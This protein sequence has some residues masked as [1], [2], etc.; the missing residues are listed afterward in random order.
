MIYLR[1]SANLSVGVGIGAYGAL[2]LDDMVY[3]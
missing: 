2:K 1:K 3:T